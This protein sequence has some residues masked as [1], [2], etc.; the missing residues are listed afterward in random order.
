MKK[1]FIA[2][3]ALITLS[4]FSLFNT[5]AI[6]QATTLT[7]RSYADSGYFTIPGGAKEAAI[8]TTITGSTNTRLLLF[9]CYDT[10]TNDCVPDNITIFNADTNAS[11]VDS[12]RASVYLS[13]NMSS[14]G[15]T[16]SDG[17]FFFSVPIANFPP[18]KK[19]LIRAY[20]RS[21][22]LTNGTITMEINFR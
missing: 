5:G 22:T 3:L 21:A 8:M 12:V 2:V 20:E 13:D 11:T 18:A 6:F 16:G 15:G 14:A 7:G 10:G 4:A 1:V 9:G 17:K 19:Y